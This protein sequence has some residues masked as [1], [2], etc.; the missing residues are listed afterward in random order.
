MRRGRVGGGELLSQPMIIRAHRDPSSAGVVDTR[1][2]GWAKDGAIQ[3]LVGGFAPNAGRHGMPNVFSDS[4]PKTKGFSGVRR[5]R[6][7]VDFVVD[8]TP[9]SVR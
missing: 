1:K 3:D 4:Y 9:F 5:K 8:G 2:Q 6:R 7:I